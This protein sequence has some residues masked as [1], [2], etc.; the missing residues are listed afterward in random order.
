MDKEELKTIIGDYLKENL[1]V[2]VFCNHEGDGYM[3]INVGILLD[4]EEIA[5]GNDGFRIN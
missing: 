2:S 4:G 3:S 1:T 5:S